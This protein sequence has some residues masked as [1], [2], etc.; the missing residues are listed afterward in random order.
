VEIWDQVPFTWQRFLHLAAVEKGDVWFDPKWQLPYRGSPK[1]IRPMRI[2][3]R[4][5]EFAVNLGL[6]YVSQDKNDKGWFRYGLTTDGEILLNHW[7]KG[8]GSGSTL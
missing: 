7:K 3:K 1:F 6:V 5:I 2:D 4:T 8:E